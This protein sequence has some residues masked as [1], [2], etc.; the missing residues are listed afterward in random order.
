MNAFIKLQVL[1]II[2]CILKII[3]KLSYWIIIYITLKN[4]F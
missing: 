1:Y 3:K 2:E 4:E